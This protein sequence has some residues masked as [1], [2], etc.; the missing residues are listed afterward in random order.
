MCDTQLS[1]SIACIGGMHPVCQW[2]VLSRSLFLGSRYNAFCLH[3]VLV[4][5]RSTS[6]LENKTVTQI[7][8]DT[9]TAISNNNKR[10]DCNLYLS[11]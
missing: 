11:I 3:I 5:T 2:R 8:R 4:V 9:I 1:L 7:I 10:P 6:C